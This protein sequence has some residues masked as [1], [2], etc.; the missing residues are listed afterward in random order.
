MLPL[1]GPVI[2]GSLPWSAKRLEQA[3]PRSHGRSPSKTFVHCLAQTIP[4]YLIRDFSFKA[5]RDELVNGNVPRR[6]NPHSGRTSPITS[7]GCRHGGSAYII[8]KSFS[9]SW[10]GSAACVDCA[11]AWYNVPSDKSGAEGSL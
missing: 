3:L 7:S 4:V 2:Q 10:N 6:S 9:K 1:G 8:G 11:E 5:R